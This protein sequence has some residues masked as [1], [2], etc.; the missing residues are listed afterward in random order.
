M[1]FDR[2]LICLVCAAVFPLLYPKQNQIALVYHCK[3]TIINSRVPIVEIFCWTLQRFILFSDKPTRRL[4]QLF[5]ECKTKH[6]LYIELWIGVSLFGYKVIAQIVKI[7]SAAEQEN[8][9]AVEIGR[10]SCRER[11]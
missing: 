5:I 2:I 6:S 9:Y 1:L 7:A 10:A 8:S 3:V 4:S 11:V